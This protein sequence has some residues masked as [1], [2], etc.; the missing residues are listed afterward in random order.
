MPNFAPMSRRRYK[1][2]QKQ[3]GAS[4]GTITYVG[5][6]VAHATRISRIEYNTAE[7]HIDGSGR[8]SNCRIPAAS[9]PFV[10]WIDVDGIHQPQVIEALGQQFNL[11][12][13][14]LEDVVNT[15][16]KPK[17]EAYDDGVL[18]VTLKM[19]HCHN[20][21]SEID[22]EH[23]SFVLGPNY[24]ISF[25]EER[26][27]DIFTPVLDRIKASAGK[28]RRNGPDYLMYALMDLIVDR[29]FEVLDFIG[30]QLDKLED[31]IV[32]VQVG[33]NGVQQPTLTELYS[34]K[35]ELTYTRRMVWPLR[36][37]IGAL[38][39]E[40]HPLI[41]PGT[42]PYLRDLYDHVT[43]VIETIDSYRE[44]I[45]GLMDV[46]LS[47][48]SNRMNSVMKTLTIFSAIFMPLTFIAGI[49][50]MNFE[51]MPELKTTN[52]YFITLG[53]MA[54]TAAGLIIYFRRRGWM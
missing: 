6:E 9:T 15:E 36:D 39:R 41:Q 2:G 53:V 25:Q 50:G 14:L 3:A 17:S 7:Y 46:Y 42:L 27:S 48:M 1:T 10:T 51:N 18:F 35:R 29:Y 20:R 40:E 26:T 22:A 47:T 19:L 28:T 5:R 16:Q 8:L 49:Y 34:L 37:M 44:L 38:I 33:G 21:I 4:P 54:A 13:L 24:L 43:Q 12:P 31:R 32:Q 23:I 52:G 45:P 30:T 11:H